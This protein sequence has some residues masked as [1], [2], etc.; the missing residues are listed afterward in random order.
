[1][2]YSTG[3]T[4][5]LILLLMFFTSTLAWNCDSNCDETK[6]YTS[7]SCPSARN[8]DKLCDGLVDGSDT[9]A[10]KIAKKSDCQKREVNT[11]VRK[12]LDHV[13]HQ[14]NHVKIELT[15]SASVL[16]HELSNLDAQ[17][18]EATKETIYN[19][20]LQLKQIANQMGENTIDKIKQN[21]IN[22]VF[23]TIPELKEESHNTLARAIA[24]SAIHSQKVGKLMQELV[25]KM[26]QNAPEIQNFLV[27]R[28]DSY[29][30]ELQS[31]SNKMFAPFVDGTL[32][33]LINIQDTVK[34][35]KSTMNSVVA[36]L[37]GIIHE[38]KSISRQGEDFMN[39]FKGEF[40]NKVQNQLQ[41]EI[42]KM[43]DQ[44]VATLLTR[45]SL[46]LL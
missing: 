36:S 12:E 16:T 34:P 42:T 23:S 30:N 37:K 21:A 27:Q 29:L 43:S 22:V 19:S 31:N 9:N 44:F 11:K 14:I 45:A 8:P 4:I 3:S 6:I 41:K 28:A 5:V 26:G 25:D 13:Q 33:H 38:V 2:N 40:K 17:L 15:K 35:V 39:E 46:P 1:M 10:C 7:Y 18:K 20:R 24:E 32:K